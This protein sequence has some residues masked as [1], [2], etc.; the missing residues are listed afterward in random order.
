[1]LAV[2]DDD[3]Q[4]KDGL[5]LLRPAS[6]ACEDPRRVVWMGWGG[7]DDIFIRINTINQY[8]K[9]IQSLILLNS[10]VVQ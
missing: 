8:K 1:M 9:S 2:G 4:V 10:L 7:D 6:A 3:G 5:L